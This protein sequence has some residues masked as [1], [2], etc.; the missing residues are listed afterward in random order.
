M[1][2][3]DILGQHLGALRLL[4]ARELES[5]GAGLR[6]WGDVD[7]FGCLLA[8]RAWVRARSETPPSNVGRGLRALLRTPLLTLVPVLRLGPR[9]SYCLA[10]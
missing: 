5:F 1:I 6:S 4:D 10:E 3:Y 7:L 2:A 8:G 9:V